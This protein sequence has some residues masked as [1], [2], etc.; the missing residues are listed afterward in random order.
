MAQQCPIDAPR[1]PFVDCSDDCVT[2]FVEHEE[3]YFDDETSFFCTIVRK[4]RWDTC[5]VGIGIG[6]H[7]F[8]ITLL[9]GEEIELEEVHRDKFSRA[10]HDQRTTTAELEFSVEE[11]AR[12]ELTNKSEYSFEHFGENTLKIRKSGRVGRRTIR[13]ALEDVATTLTE[14][15]AKAGARLSAKNEVAVAIKSEVENVYRSTRKIRNPN[16][17]QPV[18]YN[19]Y[20]IAK[21]VR[22]TLTLVE[23][24][25][26]CSPPA[27]D[28]T[29]RPGPGVATFRTPI[30]R[31]KRLDLD[32]VAPPPAWQTA[33]AATRDACPA[34]SPAPGNEQVERVAFEVPTEFEVP[35]DVYFEDLSATEGDEA[36]ARARTAL[37]PI[38]DLIDPNGGGVISEEEICIATTGFH[39]EGVVSPC[40]VCEDTELAKKEL[41]VERCRLELEMLKCEVEKCRLSLKPPAEPCDPPAKGGDSTDDKPKDTPEDKGKDDGKPDDDPGRRPGIDPI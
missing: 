28:A 1:R 32:V 14:S 37:A 19:F 16:P 31:P 17:C 13:R 4:Y 9:P 12:Q 15:V 30:S 6:R 38:D 7:V 25:L 5:E 20:Q 22:R 27:G 41:D 39:V 36:V 2:R 18:T 24:V 3:S 34:P 23:T 10:L 29:P 11:T 8:S 21:R 26:K 33:L 40:A 35:R